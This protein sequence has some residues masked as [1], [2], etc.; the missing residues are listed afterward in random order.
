MD[1]LLNYSSYSNDKKDFLLEGFRE[2]FDIGYQGPTLRQDRSQNIP[3]SVGNHQD[4]WDKLM[5][6]VALKRV[7]GP[8]AEI[9]FRNFMQSPIGL[10]PKAGNKTRLIFH[11]SFNFASGLGSLNSNVPKKKCS[12]K[13]Q[14]LDRAVEACLELL[15]EYP[16]GQVL[17]FG[18]SDLTSAFRI[19]PCKVSNFKWLLMMAVDPVS[20][21]KFYFSDK[22]L[23]FG[24]SISCSHFQAVSDGLAHITSFLVQQTGCTGRIINYLDD[25]LFIA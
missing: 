4:L 16:S 24:G 3:F 20:K 11:L 5:K 25:F 18:R 14:D 13:Y 8:F 12:V 19:L 22:S 6:E 2:G 15:K 17:Y 10:V 21:Q 1:F 9:P 23:P 7:A